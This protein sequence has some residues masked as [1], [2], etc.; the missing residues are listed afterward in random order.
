MCKKIEQLL[1][2]VYGKKCK[3]DCMIMTSTRSL[4]YFGLGIALAGLVL[5]NSI[6]IIGV[7]IATMGFIAEIYY[8]TSK[9]KR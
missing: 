3:T 2:K 8:L 9:K 7:V 5:L 4:T 1:Q 6:G